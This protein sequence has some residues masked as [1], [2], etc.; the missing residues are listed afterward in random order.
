MFNVEKKIGPYLFVGSF[1]DKYV[2]LPC[3]AQTFNPIHTG[4]FFF[5]FSDRGGGGGGGGE[6]DPDPTTRLQKK[7]SYG[8][9]F[10]GNNVYLKFYQ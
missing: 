9:K 5:I 7:T 6:E 3:L 8:H 4:L 2:R 10:S 1:N